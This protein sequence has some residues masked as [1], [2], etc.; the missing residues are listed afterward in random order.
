MSE[1][2]RAG[3]VGGGGGDLQGGLIAGHL[4]TCSL[5][6]EVC[7]PPRQPLITWQAHHLQHPENCFYR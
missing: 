3:D 6:D 1:L 4:G 2:A 7:L 5:S